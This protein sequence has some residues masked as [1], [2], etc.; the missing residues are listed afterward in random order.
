MS[1]SKKNK[2]LIDARQV[3]KTNTNTNKIIVAI[4]ELERQ[5]AVYNER[6][7]HHWVVLKTRSQLIHTS[8]SLYNTSLK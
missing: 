6:H 5:E 1:V 7:F 8:S 3:F 2:N 4:N